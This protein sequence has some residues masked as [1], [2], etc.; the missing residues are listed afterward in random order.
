M[1]ERRPLDGA[2]V[3][4]TRRPEDERTLPSELRRLGAE[5]IE[6]PC[7]RAEPLAD[8]SELAGEIEG[9]RP[10]DL[11][12]LTS[13]AGVDAVAAVVPRSGLACGV[14]AV[15]QRTAEHAAA[16]G[17]R[18]HFVASRAD[19]RTLGSE[20]PVPRG[21]I[22]LA[23]SD[24]ASRDLPAILRR[25]GARVR[26]LTAYRTV[27]EVSG[28]PSAVRRAIARRPVSIV[29]ASPSAVDALTDAVGAATL[30]AAG[31]IA[32]GRRTAERVRRR[33]GVIAA[34]TDVTDAASLVN[35]IRPP[36]RVAVT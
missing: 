7:M 4:L 14:A 20:L 16:V 23:R 27:A 29:V 36:E 9:L 13:R 24:I 28:D 17:L 30:R 3:V 32:I 5:V 10:S 21:E 31:F 26:E 12:V 2:I 18:V 19:G 25:R 15:G 6:L 11:L 8:T 34:I 22:L 35:A 33:I 1:S